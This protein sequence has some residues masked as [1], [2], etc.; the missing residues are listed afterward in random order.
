MARISPR[1]APTPTPLAVPLD[2]RSRVPLQRQL[3]DSLRDA[4]LERRLLPGTRLPGSRRLAESLEVSRTTVTLAFEQLRAEGYLRGEARSGTFVAA[5]V[6]DVHLRVP[7]PLA[8]PATASPDP[9]EGAPRR[10]PAS[11]GAAALAPSPPSSSPPGLSRRGAMLA[12]LSVTSSPLHGASGGRAFRLGTPALD[13]L[14]LQLWG[15]LLARRWRRLSAA[16]LAYAE[17]FG[18]QVLREA[19]AAHVRQARAV[20]CEPAQVL[21]VSGAQQAFDLCARVLLDAGDVAAIEDPGY[22]GMRAALEAAGAVLAPVPVDRDGVDVAALAAL[23]V[24]PRLACVTPSHQFPLGVTLSAARRLALLDWARR[25]AAWI[26]E[27]DFDSEYRFRGRPL[28]SLQGMDRDGRVVYVGTF[29][30]TLFPALRLGYLIVPPALVDPFARARAAIDRHPSALEQLVL[31]DFI[32]EGHFARHVRRMR[33]LYAERQEVLLALLGERADWLEPTPVDAG[34][35]LVAWLRHGGDDAPLA[36]RA[37]EAGVVASP[38]RALSLVPSSRGA[39]LLGF[40][41]FERDV[42]ARALDVLGRVAREAGMA[43]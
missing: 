18:A 41:G 31:A 4:I 21:V 16:Q 8:A 39:L 26:V 29:S 42:M 32:A 27:D 40:A 19:I 3:Y 38:L 28:P 9:E 2:P 30:K 11:G 33:A 12:A 14:P 37:L 34:M 13:H 10:F 23:P 35:H 7:A 25:R 24:A 36:A 20:R 22:R 43:P 6:P 1:R 17:P 15:R 5:V